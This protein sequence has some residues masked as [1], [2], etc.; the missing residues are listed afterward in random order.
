MDR[1]REV[2]EIGAHSLKLR[3][4]EETDG[5]GFAVEM[6]EFVNSRG[7]S[8]RGYLTR[9]ISHEPLP[10]ILYIH[11]HGN[12]HDIGADEILQGRPALQRPVGPDF[13]RMGI[14]ALMIEMPGFGT[15]R[16]PPESARA[17]ERLWHGKSLAGQML[18]EQQAAFAWLSAREDI[19]AE[20]IGVFGI[21]M[22]A[23]LG[24]WLAAV[25][26]RIT[27]I[28]HLCCF[29]DFAAL[30]AT[31]AH[32]LHGIYLTVPGLL[33][34]AA[35]GEIAGRIAPRPQLMALGDLD[36]LTPPIAANVALSQTRAAYADLGA[37]SNLVVYREPD[38][39]HVE[40][41]GMR[42][43]MLGFFRRHLASA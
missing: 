35:N 19:I 34:I 9:P 40:T 33:D 17:K 23:T 26:P 31:G 16:N 14:A 21:S 6:L 15:R 22:G 37:E 30:I 38:T 41:P 12:R 24:Y 5:G 1:L 8:V 2:F 3:S 13:A 11:A 4:R 32:D 18:G 43:A 28:A 25:E 7:E 39:G 29:A 10:G 36:P 42:S 20:K 27:C